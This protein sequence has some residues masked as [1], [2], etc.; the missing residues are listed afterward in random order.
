[1]RKFS[2]PTHTVGHPPGTL[3]D[4]PVEQTH[5]VSF[6]LVA[7]DES[8]FDEREFDRVEDCFEYSGREL[9]TWID[10]DG[11]HDTDATKSLGEHFDLHGALSWPKFYGRKG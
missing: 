6:K 8:A 1:M 5:S 11:V 9:Y 2:R 3:Y 7:Y 4:K 10:V